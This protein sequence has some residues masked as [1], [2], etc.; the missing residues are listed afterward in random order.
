MDPR[1]AEIKLIY[2]GVNIS[3][4]IAPFLSSLT[5]T[6]NGNGNADDLSI[7]LDDRDNKW[8]GAWIP[9]KGDDIKVEI[10]YHNW[11]KPNTK[12]VVKCGTFEVDGL[13]FKGPPDELTIQ[14]LSYPGNSSIKGERR[15]KSWEKVTL[16]QIASRIAAAAGYKLMFSTDDISYDRLDQTEETD[17]SFLSST[18]DKEG[19]SLKIT[20][21]TLVVFDD[22][23]FESQ[24]A[25]AT[26]KRGSGNIISYS[27]DLQ[28]IGSTYASCQVSYTT[29]TKKKKRT[30]KG[31]FH[32][33]GIK[34][35]VLKINERVASE[36]EA[37]RKARNALRNKNKE[38]QR[39]S[40]TLM[41]DYRLAQGVTVNVAGFGGFDGKYYVESA[42]HTA[43]GGNATTQIE[44]RKVL[45]Y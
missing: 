28:T 29:T 37:I 16:K 25:V 1:R 4:D 39:G 41:G 14:A 11:L 40:I 2:K 42:K 10:V 15:T 21:K 32:A 7:T 9:K 19:L 26:I 8:R 33:P 5:Y 38:A 34:G 30:I 18:C 13:S 20:N 6:D 22:R 44:L 3:R 35:P 31:T 45:G 17:L 12:N 24:K 23:Y 27:F 36:A 43:G